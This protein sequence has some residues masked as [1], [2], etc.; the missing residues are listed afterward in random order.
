[1]RAA[2]KR[3]NRKYRVLP[4][5]LSTGESLPTLV[6]ESDWIPV[7]VATRWAVRRRRFECM[8][9]TL[10]RDLRALAL[11]YEW[12]EKTVCSDLD[13][14]LERFVV[15]EGR[16]LDSLVTFLRVKGMRTE[17]NS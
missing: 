10:A 4:I 14:L 3:V 6:R 15:P 17:A 8:D 9:S 5:T 11:L 16:Q 7:R 2:L 1:M 12:A 13:D